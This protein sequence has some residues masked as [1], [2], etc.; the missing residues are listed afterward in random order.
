MNPLLL[1]KMH[2]YPNAEEPDKYDLVGCGKYGTQTRMT[3]QEIEQLAVFLMEWTN[4]YKA[5]RIDH[6][7]E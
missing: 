2:I 7:D 1:E 4:E 5:G 3:P 6:V